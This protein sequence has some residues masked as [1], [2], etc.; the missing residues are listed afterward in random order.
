MTTTLQPLSRHGIGEIVRPLNPVATVYLGLDGGGGPEADRT[1]RSRAIIDHLHRSGAPAATMDTLRTCLDSIAPHRTEMAIGVAGADVLFCQPIG[2]WAGRDRYG[3]GAPAHVLPLV[4][5]LQSHPPYVE[6]LIDRA[7]ADVVSVHRGTMSATTRHVDGPDDEIERNAPG[8]WAQP[9]YQRRAEDSWRHNA[10]AAADVTASAMREAGADLLLV[11]GDVRAVQLFED[12]IRDRVRTVVVRH[13][14]GGRHPD[15]SG[16][17]RGAAIHE[18]IAAYVDDTT[19]ALLATLRAELG[20]HGRGVVGVVN[21]LAALAAGRL[22]TLLVTD[23]EA[24]ERAAW[25]G[26]DVLCVDESSLGPMPPGASLR[27]GRLIDVAVRAALLT[28][29]DVRVLSDT[30]GLPEGIGGLCRFPA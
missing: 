30:S 5:W 8:G 4:S 12:R 20:P 3:H 9:R 2:G 13:V 1:L 19:A 27:A 22:R 10:A 29:A 14:P 17:A 28:D 25:F 21:T 26:P 24:D 18:H 23:D 6:V 7:G 11:A 16:G 15:G